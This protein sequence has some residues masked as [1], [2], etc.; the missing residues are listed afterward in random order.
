MTISD[1]ERSQKL[2]QEIELEIRR[3]N[4]DYAHI[5]IL[6]IMEMLELDPIDGVYDEVDDLKSLTNIRKKV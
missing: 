1:N 3:G 6:E 5:H 2:I 4:Y